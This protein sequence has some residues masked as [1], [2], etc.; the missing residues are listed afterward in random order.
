MNPQIVQSE[1]FFIALLLTGAGIGIAYVLYTGCQLARAY[2]RQWRV[3]K[4]LYAL[5]PR[6]ASTTAQAPRAI[7][8][9]QMASRPDRGTPIGD[10]ES[11]G[12]R[13]TSL[14]RVK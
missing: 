10:P 9:R 6:V 7:P 8:V 11:S 12:Y 13:T 1:H 14:R 3:R 2:W 5:A 4:E